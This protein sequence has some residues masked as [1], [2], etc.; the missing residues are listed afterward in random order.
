VRL[1]R[2][3]PIFKLISSQ[4]SP[5]V[6]ISH[7]TR[8]IAVVGSG[9]AGLSAAWLLSTQFQ[10]T[11]FEA[12]A[13]LGG[14]TH[15][16]DVT[17][18]GR[19]HPVDTGFLVFNDR[20]YPHLNALFKHLGVRY[21]QSDMSFSV[22]IDHSDIEWAGTNL[23][24]VF[25]DRRNLLRPDFLAMLRDIVRFNRR[26]SELARNDAIPDCT[27]GEFLDNEN[28]RR[29]FRNWYFLPMVASIWSA[30]AL[31]VLDFPLAPLLRFCHQHG[32]LQVS[33]RP[34]WRTV[35]GGGRDYVNRL[36]TGVTA[37]RRGCAVKKVKRSATAVQLVSDAGEEN[38][39]QIVL[40]CHPDQSLALLDTPSQPEREILSAIRYQHNT[41]VLHTDATFL[42]RRKQA[43]ASWNYHVGG[44]S[45]VGA[46][47]S[48]TYLIN[49]LQPLPFKQEVLVTLNPSRAPRPDTIIGRYAYRHP[50]FDRAAIRAQQ[51]L[52]DI[53]GVD[54]T[55]YCGAWTRN[56]FH[57]D[58]LASSITVANRFG[59]TPPWL[60]EPSA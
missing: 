16:V 28:Y 23:S 36:A 14:H 31:S 58:G 8:R 55:W 50:L 37:I 54:R 44:D 40:A 30:P 22:R 29:P 2:R 4:G 24:S 33:D 13:S 53:Q 32:L 57:E 42:P 48:L 15:T 27:L 5:I 6:G 38:F 10:V 52:D 21:A 19:T 47:V 39:D 41:A 56:G 49:R 25:A 34:R 60:M 9:I 46:P 26:A 20:T 12:E 45:I 59:V 3:S 43:W 7:E 11:L 35:I 1:S 17:L 18:E 51:R